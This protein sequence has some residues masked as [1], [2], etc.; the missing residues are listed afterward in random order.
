MAIFNKLGDIAKSASKSAGDAIE[1]SKLTAKIRA[2]KASID[3]VKID[4]GEIIWQQYADGEELTAALAELCE[5]IKDGLA[6]I[7]ILENSIA[8]IKEGEA[9]PPPK[10]EAPAE[11]TGLFC[12]SCG[13]RIAPNSRFCGSCG[14]KRED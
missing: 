11:T 5:K 7:E 8:S 9:A 14:A 1:I 2:E 10:P 4:I 12:P 13:E 3:Q 6:A